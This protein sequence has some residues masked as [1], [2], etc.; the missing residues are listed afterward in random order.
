MPK[1][2]SSFLLLEDGIICQ[3]WSFSNYFMSIGEVVFN[4]GITGYQE[5]MTDPSYFGQIILF[6]YPEIGNTGINNQDMESSTFYIK[7]VIAKNICLNPSNWRS[8]ISLVQ[9]LISHNIPHLFGVDTRFLAQ[10]LRTKGVMNGCICNTI[11]DSHKLVEKFKYCTALQNINLTNKVTTRNIYKWSSSLLNEFQYP[12]VYKIKEQ[13]NKLHVIVIDFGVKF[14]ILNRLSYYGCT[15][16]VVP[17]IT[18]SENII[19]NKPDGVL[20]SNGPGDPSL[21]NSSLNTINDLINDNIPLFGICLGHQLLSLAIG[22]STSKLKFGHRGLNHPSGLYDQVKITSQNHGF[23][24]SLNTLPQNIVDIVSWNLNDYTIA[25]IVHNLKP[26]FS[27]QY[28]P[29]ASPG[30]HDSDYLFAHFIKIMDIF[31]KNI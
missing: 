28:H 22:A 18:S 6:T 27:V 2:Y 1:I 13:V 4:T 17:S 31:K 14:N 12:S 5:I 19:A 20:L 26:C 15:V 3:G 23:V 16:T 21:I 10:H 7:G 8:Q 24:V 29:E 9:Y 25:G 30:P 11:I